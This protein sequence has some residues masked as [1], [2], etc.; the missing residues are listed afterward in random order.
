MSCDPAILA[1]GVRLGPRR[2]EIAKLRV[3]HFYVDGGYMSFWFARKGGTESGVASHPGAVARAKADLQPAGHGDD[4][5]APLFL[6]TRTTKSHLDQRRHLS[7]K[8]I[9][10]IFKRWLKQAG[11]DHRILAS[12]SMRATA[13]TQALRN[14]APIEGVRYMLGHADIRTT[15]LYDKRTEPL[16]L[17]TK[18]RSRRKTKSRRNNP[19]HKALMKSRSTVACKRT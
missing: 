14:A 16:L 15:L 2:A 8:Q 3:K 13:G 7:D 5:D 10:N 9:N 11:L 4:P 18:M 17:R 1:V 6:P 19:A 12:H